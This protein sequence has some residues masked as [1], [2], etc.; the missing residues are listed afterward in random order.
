MKS[1]ET[2]FRIEKG[3]NISPGID[4]NENSPL[5]LIRFFSGL[6]SSDYVCDYGI[7]MFQDY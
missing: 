6:I 1:S 3:L 5:E 7:K 4:N 2:D